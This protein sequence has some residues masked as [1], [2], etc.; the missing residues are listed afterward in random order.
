VTEETGENLESA[1]ERYAVV[2]KADRYQQALELAGSPVNVG[3]FVQVRQELGSEARTLGRRDVPVVDCRKLG[4]S[5]RRSVSTWITFI[6]RIL[7]LAPVSSTE[8]SCLITYTSRRRRK[9]RPG[10]DPEAPRVV[11]WRRSTCFRRNRCRCGGSAVLVVK[12]AARSAIIS[13]G[14]A[15][16]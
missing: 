10:S 13:A 14:E 11:R 1:R 9:R 8:V 5:S 6:V 7:A 3:T 16:G 15:G 4:N 12:A 2:L